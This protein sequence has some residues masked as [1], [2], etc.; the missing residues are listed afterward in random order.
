MLE[1]FTTAD[2]QT[3]AEPLLRWLTQASGDVGLHV[4]APTAGWDYI[5]YRDLA[6]QVKVFAAGLQAQELHYGD[7]V[8]LMV[9]ESE[10]FI[11]SFFGC[12]LAG[13]TPSTVMPRGLFRKADGYI[14]HVSGI[15]NA[16]DPALV[17]AGEESH[18]Y[19]Q[20][21]VKASGLPS[22]VV[23]FTVVRE[24][25]AKG[26]PVRVPADRPPGGTALLQFTSGS[27]GDPKGVRVSWGALTANVAAIRD[28]LGLTPQDRFAGWLP[29]FHDMGL[30]G[31]ML[32]SITNGVDTWILSPEQF[33]RNP[34]RWVECF[35]KYGATI[36][37]S[38]SFGYSYAA[39]RVSPDDLAGYDFSRWRIAILGAERI[40]PVGVND[41]TRLAAPFGF[42]PHALVGAYGLAEA[43]LAVT[44]VH[45]ADGSPLVKV[46]STVVAPG[47]P[48]GARRDG[49]LGRDR[50]TGEHLVGCGRPLAG[51]EV[52]V[53]DDEG[54]E[55]PDGTLG[56]I[57]I[58]GT[59]LADGYVLGD[60]RTIDF[61]PAGHLTGDAGFLL[62]GELFVVGRIGD[63]IKVRGAMVFAEDLEAELERVSG[64]RHGQVAVLL[65]RSG[66]CDR[67]VVLIESSSPERWND[68]IGTIISTVR[69]RTSPEFD[70]PVYAGRSGAIART[71]SGKPR[72]RVL[73]RD[74]LAGDLT[75]WQLATQE[76]RS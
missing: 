74:Y 34:G 51:L 50:G 8:T 62:D 53:L 33:I 39:R 58:S 20:E 26:P 68:R 37:T 56:E 76:G 57:S 6:V 7:V 61:D 10:Q 71:S 54:A 13:V 11:V 55:V 15:L 67:A 73:W 3:A 59:S 19:A 46:P 75:D 72:R 16:A 40:D 65:G 43:T 49:L 66:G 24:T 35:G 18:E 28:W 69:A 44:G 48:V 52:H 4:A 30:I 9:S 1:T 36:T 17:M 14:S 21:A 5:S 70:C 23:T 12:L 60:R 27:S 38:P 29:L 45:P 32:T 63:S 2:S 64:A 25:G 31:Q 42:D 47:S 41:F 22:P